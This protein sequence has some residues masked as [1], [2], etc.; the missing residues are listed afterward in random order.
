VAF[1]WAVRNTGTT[2]G[3][4]RTKSEGTLSL[5][6]DCFPVSRCYRYRFPAPHIAEVRFDHGGLFHP[7]DFSKGAWAAAHP[8]G[9]DFYRG[10][11]RVLA[12]ES[13]VATWYVTGPRKNQ[14]LR[15]RY[16]RS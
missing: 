7:L 16:R 13:W 4:Y 12:P 14:V 2:R 11:F 1:W 10:R 15:S 3:A 8:C 6:G 9:R 5:G